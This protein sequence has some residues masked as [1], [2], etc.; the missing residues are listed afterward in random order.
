MPFELPRPTPPVR[1]EFVQFWFLYLWANHAV[2]VAVTGSAGSVSDLGGG[3][4]EALRGALRVCGVREA[5]SGEVPTTP[6]T[7]L[8]SSPA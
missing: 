1:T 5:G 2:L 3:N 6:Y 7:P 4:G 8:L